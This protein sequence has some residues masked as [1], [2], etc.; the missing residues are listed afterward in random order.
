MQCPTIFMEKI[1]Q[2]A[3]LCFRQKT[4]VSLWLQLLHLNY[5]ANELPSPD[6]RVAR[7]L[8]IGEQPFGENREMDKRLS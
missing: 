2:L 3:S 4:S 5:T 6:L 7:T 8:S 1:S